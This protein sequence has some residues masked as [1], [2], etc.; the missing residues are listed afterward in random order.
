MNINSNRKPGTLSQIG[1]SLE[2]FHFRF[3]LYGHLEPVCA[4]SV[5]DL[6]KS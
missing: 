2:E 1:R 3:G 4:L 5:G 6:A